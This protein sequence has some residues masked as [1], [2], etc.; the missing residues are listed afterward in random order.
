MSKKLQII[1]SA[2]LIA[3]IS[4]TILFKKEILFIKISEVG[5]NYGMTAYQIRVKSNNLL[6]VKC[7]FKNS[8]ALRNAPEKRGISVVVGDLLCRRIGGLSPEETKEKLLDLGVQDLSI[9]A[10]ED[11][12]ILSF[13]VLKDKAPEALKFLSPIFF[14][15]EFSKNDL[16]F[17]KEKYPITSD[18]DL[19][20][21]RELLFDK[22][23]ETLYTNHNYGLNVTGNARSIAGISEDDVRN[24]VKSNFSR[25]NLEVFFTGD[26]SQSDVETHVETLFSKIPEKGSRDF[27]DKI[28]DVSSCPLSEEKDYV[29]LKPNMKDIVGIICGFRVDNLD[30]KEEAAAHVIINTLFDAKIG[31]FSQGLR[32]RKIAYSC[33]FH[34]IQRNQSNVFFLEIYVYKNDLENYKKYLE[35]K[36][37]Q[38]GCKLNLKKLERT[39]D[40]LAMQSGVGFA[41]IFDVDKKMKYSS[42]PFSQITREIF[43]N[44]MKKLFD[45]SRMRVVYV[46]SER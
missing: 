9:R 29:I 39:K 25:D 35:E 10:C 34:F 18:L 19:S 14:R 26:I 36:I 27:I 43:S 42:L 22:L 1:I 38:Y 31:D 8:G 41:N 6:Y 13:Y 5:N 21:P 4:A 37:S 20:H 16:E 44:T 28:G 2:V 33:D 24:F 32:A 3:L 7:V 30:R 12:F 40:Q 17:V 23:M 45:R 15:P 11:D 46:Q